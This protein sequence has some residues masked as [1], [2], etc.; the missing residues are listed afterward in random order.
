M[1]L[2]VF[3]SNYM[4]QLGLSDDVV[5]T[6]IPTRHPFF[7]DKKIIKIAAG[8]LHAFALCENNSLYSW[9]VN[10]DF[11]LSREGDE[12]IP[13]LVTFK[14]SDKEQIVDIAAGAS[15]TALLT[16]KG[17]VFV[18]GTFK[19]TSGI[20]GFSET[21]KFA[22][23]FTKIPNAKRIKKISAGMNHLIMIDDKFHMWSLGANESYQLGR[24][25]SE[26]FPKRCL[27]IQQ[28]STNLPRKLNN[29]FIEAFSG[30]YHSFSLNT[31]KEL[32]GWGSNYNG[33]LGMKE[34]ITSFN[35]VKINLPNISGAACG[36]NHSLI[37]SDGDL[38]GIGE[39]SN[40]QLG[41]QSGKII[42]SPEL[43]L[44]NVVKVNCGND[45]SFAQVGNDLYSWG[46]NNCGELGFENDDV[47]LPKKIPFEFGEILDFQCGCDF[48]MVLTM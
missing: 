48:T 41:L 7:E 32:Y 30:G 13:E 23:T 16:D 2:F 27:N 25:N 22:K 15:F 3:G 14:H 19:S 47:K 33:Q 5:N 10:D 36:L 11:A 37:I 26:R 12:T 46:L 18:T 35:R 21:A 28:I 43:I 45:Y 6:Y 40:G 20:L 17:H 42:H 38:Y 9:G 29:K 34:F 8:K 31:N 1:P 44:K 39:N 4:S 24:I